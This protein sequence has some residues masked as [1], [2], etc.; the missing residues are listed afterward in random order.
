MILSK[1]GI[2]VI[3]EASDCIETIEKAR[4]LNH[5][6]ILMDLV[7]PR[8]SSVDAILV[9]IAQD[10]EACAIIPTCVNEEVQ[11]TTAVRAGAAGYVLKDASHNELIEA[12][13]SAHANRLS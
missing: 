13:I 3:G 1:Y 11:I 12:I 6:V 8:K 7:M 4:A 5:D 10:P 2:E 9:I